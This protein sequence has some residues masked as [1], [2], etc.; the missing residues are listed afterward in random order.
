MNP[1]KYKKGFTMAELLIVVAIIAVLVAV[2]I[3]VFNTQAEKARQGVDIS[4][5]RGA[6]AAIRLS[7]IEGITTDGEYH[8]Y[9][10]E[11]GRFLNHEEASRKYG[12][13]ESTYGFQVDP[14]KGYGRAS[15][16]KLLVDISGLSEDWAQQY[17]SM[18]GDS[19][20][21]ITGGIIEAE[22]SETTYYMQ[23]STDT[24]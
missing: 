9:D 1:I 2:A 18:I 5:L 22:W 12:F 7:Q 3:P 10:P 23:F 20:D 13:A 11:T 6:Y 14:D 24:D 19:I 21:S 15:G 16:D 17:A 8:F 4:N